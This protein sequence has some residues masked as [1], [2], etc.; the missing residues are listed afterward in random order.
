MERELTKVEQA[1]M[2]NVKAM[3]EE[4]HT[5]FMN[6]VFALSKCYAQNSPHHAL[7]A[8]HD[9]ESDFQMF[10]MNLKKPEAHAMAMMVAV[11]TS[12]GDS[13][14]EYAH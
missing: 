12:E 11:N 10:G 14:Q 4:D 2:E 1:L 9:G 13:Q 5:S 6:V 8:I 3:D 7:V